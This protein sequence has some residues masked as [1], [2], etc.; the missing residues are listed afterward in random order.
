MAVRDGWI[1][2]TIFGVLVC[3]PPVAGSNTVEGQKRTSRKSAI[4]SRNLGFVAFVPGVWQCVQQASTIAAI[5][6]SPNDQ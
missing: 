1:I 5:S 2:Y 3:L 6:L 4:L